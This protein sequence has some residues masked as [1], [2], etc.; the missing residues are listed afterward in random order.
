MISG[1]TLPNSALVLLLFRV[2]T[3]CHVGLTISNAN[4]SCTFFPLPLPTL[5]FHT[6][7]LL[8]G[9]LESHK[10]LDMPEIFRNDLLY[11][12]ESHTLMDRSI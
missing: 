1:Q 5:P 11:K 6:R 4:L 9:E 8:V 2:R 10:T 7:D 12:I 3:K